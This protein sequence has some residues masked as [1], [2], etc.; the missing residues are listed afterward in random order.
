LSARIRIGAVA[1][2]QIEEAGDWWLRNRP[3]APLAFVE[4][5]A[6][7]LDLLEAVPGAGEPIQIVR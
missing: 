5:L 1:Q 6:A 4:D 2:G 3:K 7:A